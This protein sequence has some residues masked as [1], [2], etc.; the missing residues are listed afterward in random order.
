V[1]RVTRCECHVSCGDWSTCQGKLAHL[2]GTL[3]VSGCHVSSS[4]NAMC[5]VVIGIQGDATWKIMAMP[6]VRGTIQPPDWALS[7]EWTRALLLWD[8]N[9][10]SGGYM[11]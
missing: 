7:L 3:V 10:T 1:P 2:G 9:P 5:Q 6:H 8:D 11:S 4:D